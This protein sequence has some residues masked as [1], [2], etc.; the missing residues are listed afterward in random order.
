[1]ISYRDMTFCIAS[2]TNRECPRQYNADVRREAYEWWG[3]DN[4]PVSLSDF[5]GNCDEYTPLKEEN[6][7]S[8]Q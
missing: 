4:F 2:C 5:S 7:A 3:N 1:M 6:H 8:N